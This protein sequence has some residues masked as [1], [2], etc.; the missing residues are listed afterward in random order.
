M[1]ATNKFLVA[2]QGD[3]LLMMNPPRGSF[4]HDD[5][6]MLAA[7][8]VAMADKATISYQDAVDAVESV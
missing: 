6:V 1:D 5:A 7:W 3:K 2:S 8:L 4:S